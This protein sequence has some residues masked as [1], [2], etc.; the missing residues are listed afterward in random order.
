MSLSDLA[1]IGSFISGVAVLISLIYLGLQ[2]RQNASAQRATAHQSVQ[3]F[4][5]QHQRMLMDGALAAIFSRGLA[6]E[7]DMTEVELMQFHAMARDFLS[8]HEECQWLNSRGMLD[9]DGFKTSS[10]GLSLLLRYPGF[11]AAWRLSRFSFNNNY[12]ELVDADA[13]AATSQGQPRSYLEAWK[14]AVAAEAP[15]PAG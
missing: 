14:S 2:I 5:R 6:A 3:S 15:G 9:D 12:R 1:S 11:R 7:V 10:A 13:L 8:F 4:M